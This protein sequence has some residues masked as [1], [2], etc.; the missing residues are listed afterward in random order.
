MY[1]LNL[2][3]NVY[4]LLLFIA[5][6]MILIDKKVNN[7][8]K[9]EQII[10]LLLAIGFGYIVYKLVNAYIVFLNYVISANYNGK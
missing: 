5:I 3:F 9:K 2:I 4:A 7:V 10:I 6:F 8:V 1:F